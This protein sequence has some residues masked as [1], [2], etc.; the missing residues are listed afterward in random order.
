MHDDLMKK[1]ASPVHTF[2]SIRMYGLYSVW[3]RVNE[4]A[5]QIN[6][7]IHAIILNALRTATVEA[8]VQV[9]IDGAA[10]HA[11]KYG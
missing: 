2:R 1:C 7:R 4:R 8:K 11:R 6:H 3:V 10:L 5:Q 9:P